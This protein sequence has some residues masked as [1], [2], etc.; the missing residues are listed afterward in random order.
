METHRAQREL[1]DDRQRENLLR[2]RKTWEGKVC[3]WAREKKSGWGGGGVGGDRH[4]GEIVKE[5]S[6]RNG[7][8]QSYELYTAVVQTFVAVVRITRRPINYFPSL[9]LIAIVRTAPVSLKAFPF[10][11]RWNSS[12]FL[13]AYA[14][15][16][17]P[18]NLGRALINNSVLRVCMFVC[19]EKFP[20]KRKKQYTIAI[21][22]SR[23][24]IYI[25][26]YIYM[27]I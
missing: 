18:L 2:V 20:R 21:F 1:E 12:F 7:K 17:F 22:F 9:C 8:T 16:C 27:Y 10:E 14:V 25:Y 13:T 11:L 24:N 26:I 4:R 5:K 19:I 3:C 23:I 15:S 6:A